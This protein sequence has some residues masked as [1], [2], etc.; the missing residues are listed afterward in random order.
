[1]FHSSSSSKSPNCSFDAMSLAWPSFCSTPLTISQQSFAPGLSH[2]FGALSVL[3]MRHA[4][5]LLPSKRD[6]HAPALSEDCDTNRA[7]ISAK[8]YIMPGRMLHESRPRAVAVVRSEEH[9][10]ELQS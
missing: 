8:V 3:K 4:S 6:F 9:T 10:S 2:I 5:R 1:M 7:S